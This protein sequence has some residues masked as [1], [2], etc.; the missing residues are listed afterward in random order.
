LKIQKNYTNWNGPYLAYP[1]HPTDGIYKSLEHT[2]Y[3]SVRTASL[4]DSTW[5]SSN[6]G[7]CTSGNPCFVWSMINGVPKDIATAADIYIDGV[8]DK[9]EGNFRIHDSNGGAAFAH[10]YLKGQP[11]LNQP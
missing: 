6:L 3:G 1:K 7:D 9:T 11:T 4:S 10:V 5:G 8:A 2:T